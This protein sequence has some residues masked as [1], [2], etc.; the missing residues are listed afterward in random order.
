MKLNIFNGTSKL[1]SIKETDPCLLANPDITALLTAFCM[2][3][4]HTKH[5][6]QLLQLS[7]HIIDLFLQSLVGVLKTLKAFPPVK[8][9]RID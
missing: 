6:V 4:K 8:K 3:Y 1:D 7:L 2:L 9:Y 5:I